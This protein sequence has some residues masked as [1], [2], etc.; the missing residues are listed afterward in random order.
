M[1]GLQRNGPW[2]KVHF[3]FGH[4]DRSAGRMVTTAFDRSDFSREN[5]KAFVMTS[6]VSEGCVCRLWI[7]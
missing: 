3:N 7:F 4:S 2:L 6:K 5:L 1:R